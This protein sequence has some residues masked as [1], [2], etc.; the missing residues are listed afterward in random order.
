MYRKIEGLAKSKQ[1][2][3][4]TLRL[5]SFFLLFLVMTNLSTEII[6][7]HTKKRDVFAIVDDSRSMS[8]SDGAVQR[9][10]VVRSLVQSKTFQNLSSQFDMIP[11]VFGGDVLKLN[12]FDSLKFDQPFTNI[13]SPLAEA[14]RLETNAHAAFAIL[15]TDGNYN[16]GG[17]PVD[18]ARNLPFPV[19]SVGIGDSTQPKDIIAREIIPAPSIYAG[20]QSIV[21]AVVSS[22]G[23]GGK[24]VA[25]QLL[26][27]RKIIDSQKITLTEEGNIELSFDYTPESVGTHILSVHVSPLNGEFDHR[28][29][30]TSVSVDVLKG[31]YSVLLV[32]GEPASDVA[33]LRRNIESDEDFDLQVLV[34]RDGNNFYQPTADGKENESGLPNETI[35]QKYD[36]VLLYDFPNSQSSGTLNQ[37]RRILNSTAYVYFAGKDFSSEQVKRLPRLPFAIREFSPT[38]SGGEF[39]V[40]ISPVNSGEPSAD[41]QPLY[42]LINDNSSLIP[43]LYYQRIECVPDSG[44]VPLAVPVLNG[45][46]MSSPIFLVSEEGRSA[47]FLA[48]GLWRM[49]LM[50]SISGLK[51]D[52]LQDFIATLVRN[53]INSGKQKLLTVN[54]DKKSYD[55]SE[56]INFTSL[57]VDQTGSPVNGAVIDI[58]IRNETTRKFASDVQLNRSGN[59]SYTGSATGLGE[60]KYSYYAQAKTSSGFLG[61]DSGTI[62][63]ES[64]NKEFIQTAMNAHLLEQVASV[65]GGQ[66]LTPREF[67][68]GKLPIK[69]EWSE[70]VALNSE[71]KF[72]LLSSLPI[73]A[74]VFLLLGIEWT[75]RKIWGLP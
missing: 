40:G 17:N 24:S 49:Q 44:G 46:R 60:G 43:P 4:F 8:L 32:A 12:D 75:M 66:F 14:S 3:L 30:S 63:V 73:L 2:F 37:I 39:Q 21:R 9:A 5:I 31:K 54:T 65:T 19:Y 33:S 25:V 26:E 11:V 10:R 42:A 13:E 7:S 71:N 72:E 29:N 1:F 51:S 45:V 68:D 52:F 55:P 27:D 34:Q 62:V 28:N 41:L 59:G 74:L 47:A 15:I 61:T 57:L 58:R 69:P 48:Y 22:F 70:P 16:E 36:A 23:F 20:K 6:H 67:I 50:G 64:L 35:S 56:A 18:I 53:L 38:S